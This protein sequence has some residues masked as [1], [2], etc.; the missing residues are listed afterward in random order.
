MREAFL[1]R[2]TALAPNFFRRASASVRDNPCRPDST[3]AQASA[4]CRRLTAVRVSWPA[5][6]SRETGPLGVVEKICITPHG[7][8]VPE[9][10]SR[11]VDLGYGGIQP[12][13]RS[14]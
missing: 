13:E 5:V 4:G 2:V 11:N 12:S 9:F 3:A 7:D 1:S 8:N 6:R 14:V 10:G